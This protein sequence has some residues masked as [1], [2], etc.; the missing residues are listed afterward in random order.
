MTGSPSL[1]VGLMLLALASVVVVNAGGGALLLA[2]VIG[3]A[4]FHAPFLLSMRI[5][6]ALGFLYLGLVKAVGWLGL[7]LGS[8]A[9]A[10]FAFVQVLNGLQ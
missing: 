3:L 4:V 2:A 10:A 7:L 6:L 5:R 1:Y 9:V 8:A